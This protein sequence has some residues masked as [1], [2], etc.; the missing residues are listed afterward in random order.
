LNEKP[1]D[2]A[3]EHSLGINHCSDFSVLQKDKVVSHAARHGNA[4][5]QRPFQ[6]WKQRS[7]TLGQSFEK[8]YDTLGHV[9]FLCAIT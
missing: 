4:P 7:F 9:A 2:V 1:C 8:G 5:K 6:S 3:S